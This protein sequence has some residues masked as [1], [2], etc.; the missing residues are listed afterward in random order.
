[1]IQT[2]TRRTWETQND[3]A[4][5]VRVCRLRRCAA[6]LLLAVGVSPHT[7]GFTL[8]Q[9]GMMLLEGQPRTRRIVLRDTLY[10]LMERF[11]E[12]ET[13]AEHAMRDA[14]RL[15]Q[16]KAQPQCALFPPAHIPTNAEFLYKL[17]AQLQKQLRERE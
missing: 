5:S 3:G 6:E 7:K 14:I 15:T 12:Q 16:E 11:S 10:P 9:N 17:S 13:S 1:M 8:L 4:R 2:T